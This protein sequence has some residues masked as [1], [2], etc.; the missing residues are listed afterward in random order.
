[1]YR[2]STAPGT[3]LVTTILP[4]SGARRPVAGQLRTGHDGTHTTGRSGLREAVAPKP[5]HRL[6]RCIDLIVIRAI[7]V[8]RELL[9]KIRHR[10]CALRDHH[11]ETANLCEEVAW[12]EPTVLGWGDW[13]DLQALS[14]GQLVDQRGTC[15]L[16]STSTTPGRYF[17]T[18]AKAS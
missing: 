10:A 1:M 13:N 17:R 12:Y 9:H 15:A 4:R 18:N 8:R 2:A 7:R 11:H 3:L 16:R 5:I 14:V 6:R